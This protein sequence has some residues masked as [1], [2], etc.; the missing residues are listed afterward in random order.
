VNLAEKAAFAFDTRRDSL[1]AGSA[2]KYIEEGLRKRGME[3]VN[4]RMSATV[5]SL[6]PEKGKQDF[7]NKEEWKEWKHTNEG[8]I[9]GEEKKFERLGVQIGRTLLNRRGVTEPQS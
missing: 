7:E 6:Q 8:L 9:E 2:A 4:Q 1:L 5:A 3:I